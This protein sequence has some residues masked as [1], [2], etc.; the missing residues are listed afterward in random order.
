MLPLMS[1]TRPTVTGSSSI[2]KWVMVCST[3]SSKTLKCSFSSPVTGRF[4]GSQHGDRN[5][6]Q[7][8]I[9]A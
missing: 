8:D 6:H 3:L 9:D 1:K 5:Q 2:E 7:V 4:C